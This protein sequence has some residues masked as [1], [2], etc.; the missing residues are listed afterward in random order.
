V[1]DPAVDQH[2]DAVGQRG[3][4]AEVLLDQQHRDRTLGG[5]ALQ[6]RDQ[7]VDDD[8]REAFGRLVHDEEPRVREQRARDRKH[9]LLAAGELR[10]AV[11]LALR[12]PRERRIAR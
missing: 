2:Q 10:T 4:H 6:H 9:L 12:E 5:E 7:L 1:R 3:G 11:R 8:R